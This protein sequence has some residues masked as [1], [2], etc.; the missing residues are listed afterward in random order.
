M[1][2]TFLIIGAVATGLLLLAFIFDDIFDW[3]HA[4]FLNGVLSS[5]ALFAFFAGL[6]WAGVFTS[7]NTSLGF[8]G[9]LVVSF[10]SGLLASGLVSTVMRYLEHK[11]SGLVLEE[12][13]IGRHAYVVSQI[14]AGGYGKI[15]VGTTGH[16]KEVAAL[17][18]V[19]L[20]T[21]TQVVV[22]SVTGPG[23]VKV[24]VLEN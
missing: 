12:D 21:G 14:P 15:E 22:E 13:L 9:V 3:T 8:W 2:L 16:I 4:D 23:V 17:S 24:K 11:E 7:E 10:L 20:S 5:G 19:P 6:G 1:T 18:L